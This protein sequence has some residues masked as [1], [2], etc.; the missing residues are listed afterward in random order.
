[1]DAANKGA[2]LDTQ[3]LLSQSTLPAP[4]PGVTVAPAAC[5]VARGGERGSRGGRD[6][7]HFPLKPKAGI[8]LPSNGDLAAAEKALEVVG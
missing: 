2:L 1:M 4:A 6:E 8:R 5:A 7:D 3:C